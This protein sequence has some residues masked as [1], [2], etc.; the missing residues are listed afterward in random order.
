MSTSGHIPVLLQEV[1]ELTQPRANENVIDCTLGLGGYAQKFLA[2]IAPNGKLLGIDRDSRALE[3]A[4]ANLGNFQERLIP[5]QGRFGNL[6]NLTKD[7]QAVDIIVAD[8]GLSSLQLDDEKR[9]FSFQELGPLDMRMDQTS[10]KTAAELLNILPVLEIENI[11]REY[12]EEPRAKEIAKAI[13]E[14]RRQKVFSTSQDLVGV[15]DETYRKILKAP[16]GRKL[17]FRRQIH[18]ATRTFQALRIAVNAEL[19]EL[20]EL[21]AQAWGMLKVN[22]R[23]AIVSF[24]SLED[25]KVKIFFRKLHQLKKGLLLA[26]KPVQPSYQ[27][28][29]T[30]PR[31][32]SAKLRVIKKI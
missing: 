8:L 23:L 26:K 3:I 13:V 30:N 11:L 7:F 24:H 20:D 14:Q 17:W 31:A 28:I 21:L 6:K 1:V 5:R 16:V 10:G 18:P 15:I 22:G 19:E 4:K 32:H 29:K 2:A 27:E 9:G 12:G 25:R